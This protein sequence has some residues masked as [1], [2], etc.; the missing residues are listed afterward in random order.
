M[1]YFSIL[2]N[3]VRNYLEG[4]YS[5]VTHS[6]LGDIS[7]LW[8][9]VHCLIHRNRVESLDLEFFILPNSLK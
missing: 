4:I 3:T 9:S 6:L 1:D 7:P 5:R 2:F 8:K